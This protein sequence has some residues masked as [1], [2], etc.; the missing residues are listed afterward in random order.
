MFSRSTEQSS[1]AGALLG[2]S[3]A[4]ILCDYHL[5]VAWVL[6]EIV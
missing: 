1:A 5:S 6:L 3:W 4:F 2:I